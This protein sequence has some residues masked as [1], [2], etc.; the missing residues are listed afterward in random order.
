ML[1]V[2][3]LALTVKENM[4]VQITDQLLIK[5]Q[6]EQQRTHEKQTPEALCFSDTV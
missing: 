2:R 4:R 1:N 6:Q 5:K 3:H